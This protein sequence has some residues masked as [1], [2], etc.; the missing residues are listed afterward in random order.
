MTRQRMGLLIAL[1]AV[2]MAGVALLLPAQQPKLPRAKS[3]ADVYGAGGYRGNALG[4]AVAPPARDSHLEQQASDALQTFQAAATD[5]DRAAAG[6]DLRKV[7]EQQF[8]LLMKQRE[9][10]LADL[11]VRLEELAE[12]IRKR[13][14]AKDEIVRLRAQVLLNEAQGLGFY[15]E[16]GAHGFDGGWPAEADPYGV[17]ADPGRTPNAAT[18]AAAPAARAEPAPRARPLTR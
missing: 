3:G 11:R 10:Q 16:A 13:R 18:P 4:L 6:D 2:V 14:A 7:L 5:G 9:E 15:P 12:Q 1:P 8:E 17:K